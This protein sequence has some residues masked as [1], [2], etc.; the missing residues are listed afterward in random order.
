MV[1]V[2]G[3]V[4]DLARCAALATGLDGLFR[5]EAAAQYSGWPPGSTTDGTSIQLCFRVD[6]DTLD[7]AGMTNIDFD[8]SAFPCRARMRRT[9]D[10]SAA[11][12][13]YV[14]EVN[15][16]SGE[17]PRMPAGTMIIPV[18]D[19]GQPRAQL[20]LG[21]KQTRIFWTKVFEVP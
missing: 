20:L 15:P 19:G 21:H 2:G 7:V 11:V 1:P 18:R 5:T 8:G 13:A 14:G 17:P 10:G 6:D 16:Y 12:T 4:D 3:E 9:S